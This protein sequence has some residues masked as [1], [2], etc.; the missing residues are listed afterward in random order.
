MGL[1][2]LHVVLSSFA[3]TRPYRAAAF[4]MNIKHHLFRN[5]P[6]ITKYALDDHGDKTHQIHGIIKNNDVP[7]LIERI[8]HFLVR[9]DGRIRSCFDEGVTVR[10]VGGRLAVTARQVWEGQAHGGR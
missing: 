6:C 10:A 5:I 3:A 8:I 7:R 9:H 1:Q 2:L 4:L